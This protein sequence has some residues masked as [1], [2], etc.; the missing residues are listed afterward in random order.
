MTTNVNKDTI[1]NELYILLVLKISL[2]DNNVY[3]L[4][5]LTSSFKI[6][7]FNLIPVCKH[8]YLPI[9]DDSKK[10]FIDRFVQSVVHHGPSLITLTRDEQGDGQGS[11]TDF[12]HPA[13]ENSSALNYF[14]NRLH[15]S[16]RVFKRVVWKVMYLKKF[17]HS[18]PQ[19]LRVI[20]M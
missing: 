8:I 7:I 2:N 13:T 3:L 12:L 10:T 1:K 6:S 9:A 18:T 19:L 14:K 5:L 11:A 20:S 17:F 4:R 16:I 15:V